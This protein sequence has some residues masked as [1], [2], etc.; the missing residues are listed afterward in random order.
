[1][2]LDNFGLVYHWPWSNAPN[3]F[4]D[5]FAKTKLAQ[6]EDTKQQMAVLSR[7]LKS[8]KRLRRNPNAAMFES[9][10]EDSAAPASAG[11]G[12]H[13]KVSGEI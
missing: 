9:R 10:P 8:Y 13:K 2:A 11:R 1:M 3:T 5:I 12:D 7:S 6:P 4:T